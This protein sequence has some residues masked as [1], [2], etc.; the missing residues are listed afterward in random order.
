MMVI[1]AAPTEEVLSSEAPKQTIKNQEGF[2]PDFTLHEGTASPTTLTILVQYFLELLLA[3]DTK[4]VEALYQHPNSIVFESEEFQIL[5]QKRR[6]FLTKATVKKY[7]SEIHGPKGYKV[8][9][10]LSSKPE[11]EPKMHKK[12]YILLR[13]LQHAE[14]IVSGEELTMWKEEESKERQFL[15]DVRQGKYGYKELMDVAKQKEE[16]IEHLL[17]QSTLPDDCQSMGEYVDKWILRIRDTNFITKPQQRK[18]F[19]SS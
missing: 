3:G 9:E 6:A 12:F 8:V 18:A 13:L 5:K 10:A 11:E 2:E 14:Q 17:Q 15:M 4:M 1:A 19:H 7:I 16:H